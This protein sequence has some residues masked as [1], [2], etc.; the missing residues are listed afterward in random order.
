MSDFEQRI[1]E[2]TDLLLGDDEGAALQWASDILKG[3]YSPVDFFN[4]VFT[5]TMTRIGD[6]FGR[7]EIFLP[8]LID[9]A[10]RAQL[11]SDQVVQP[12]LTELGSDQKM[13]KGKILIGSVQGDLH[14]IG[15][16]MVIL[17]L[18]V[19]G[20]EV[21]DMG[22]DVPV[23]TVLEMA[24]KEAPQIVGLSSLM[25]TSQPYMKEVVERRDG[26]GFKDDYD[27]IVGGA[28]ITKEYAEMIGADAYGKSAIEAVVECT[29]LIEKQSK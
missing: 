14:D 21:I 15:K 23:A 12:M 1:T 4:Q 24:K 22:V 11:I 13:I 29:A 28:P 7:M 17:M 10:E 3:G 8:E 20:F 2:M 16:N 19:N 18:R 5:P 6:K 25:T 26:F 9:S 27:V